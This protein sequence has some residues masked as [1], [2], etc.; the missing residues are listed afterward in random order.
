MTVVCKSTG[1]VIDEDKEKKMQQVVDL[2][3]VQDS[4]VR[5]G[6]T[7]RP[8]FKKNPVSVD[9]RHILEESLSDDVLTAVIHCFMGVPR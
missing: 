9:W 5:N 4:P 8:F 1:L 6:E 2:L 3:E 7:R